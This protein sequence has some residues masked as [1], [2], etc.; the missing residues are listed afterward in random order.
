MTNINDNT[1]VCPKKITPTA[2]TYELIGYRCRQGTGETGDEAV[3][4]GGLV[5][6][7]SEEFK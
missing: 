4:G 7:W 6:S 1:M 2:C 3:V 5:V